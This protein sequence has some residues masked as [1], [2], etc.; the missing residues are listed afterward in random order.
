MEPQPQKETLWLQD[1]A[2][3]VRVAAK[4][5]VDKNI[6]VVEYGQQVMWRLGDPVVLL[7]SDKD[8]WD[9]RHCSR[10]ALT[11][12]VVNTLWSVVGSDKENGNCICVGQF[13]L[14]S[15]ATTK[16]LNRNA[17]V[18]AHEDKFVGLGQFAQVYL[19]YNYTQ[20]HLSS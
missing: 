7:V 3:I 10:W 2:P 17:L 19:S 12:D 18:P 6:P 1:H 4:A 14:L 20:M 13:H 16:K 11:R 5:L 15:S 9:I 8:F